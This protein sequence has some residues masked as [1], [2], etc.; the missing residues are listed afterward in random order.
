MYLKMKAK[1]E[2][3]LKQQYE[4]NGGTYP[5]VVGPFDKMTQE[6]FGTMMSDAVG[7]VLNT[8]GNPY[9]A[10]YTAALLDSGIDFNDDAAITAWGDANQDLID[11][12]GAYAAVYDGTCVAKGGMI[13][14]PD[15]SCSWATKESCES[16]YSWPPEEGDKYA[17]WKTEAGG[18]G[19]PACLTASFGVRGIC[20]TNDLPYDSDRGICVIDEKYCLTKSA[21]WQY[22]SE[23]GENDCKIPNGQLFASAIFGTTI[24]S[25]LNQLFNPDQYSKCP[26]GAIDDG[27]FCRVVNCP[28]GTGASGILGN[29]ISKESSALSAGGLLYGGVTAGAG[30]VAAGI[31]GIGKS[32]LCYPFCKEG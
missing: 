7:V 29:Q 11:S 19:Q 28:D 15:H 22:D 1:L 27:Y 26:D 21:T 18:P 17:E 20:H 31:G 30:I 25:G 3:D 5:N 24:V 32:Q 10:A 9:T 23:I 4:E 6:E 12:D 16:S 2:A 8:D 14:G 13:L